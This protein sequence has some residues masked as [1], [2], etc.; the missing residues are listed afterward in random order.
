MQTSILQDKEPASLWWEAIAGPHMLIEAVSNKLLSGCSLLLLTSD[1]FPWRWAFRGNIENL[2]AR[3]DVDVEY[4]DCKDS[5]S[6]G[7]IGEFVLQ[8]TAP[9]EVPAYLRCL[10]DPL[11][12]LRCSKILDH[13]IIWLKGVPNQY[14]EKFLKF[15]NSYRSTSLNEG[16]LLLELEYPLNNAAHPKF[17]DIVSYNDFV[18][19]TDL[20]LFCTLLAHHYD[21]PANLRD[22]A[23]TVITNLCV[24]DG[25]VAEALFRRMDFSNDEPIEALKDCFHNQEFP[26]SRGITCIAQQSA[27]PFHLL[28]T[29]DYIQL[30]RRVWKAQL[31]IAFPRIE[32][33]R[34]Q[35][36]EQY[37]HSLQ[38]ALNTKYWDVKKKCA[39]YI[40]QFESTIQDPYDIELGT[41]HYML[42]VFRADDRM[43]PLLVVT[44]ADRKRIHFLVDMRNR[45]LAHIYNNQNCSPGEM[46]EILNA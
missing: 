36:I 30:I 22:Y 46:S 27:H 21:I 11:N 24:T 28:L 16:S 23:A 43:T 44:P 4:I 6:D 26:K 29:K 32:L 12:W 34:L 1:A 38:E 14:H 37:Q 42:Q 8:Q 5:Y 33:E 40:E 7:D 3:E 35:L 2:L 20:H 45:K 31:Q 15:V 18:T 41:L 25:E 13:K 9:S 17:V 39:K 10:K 19:Q